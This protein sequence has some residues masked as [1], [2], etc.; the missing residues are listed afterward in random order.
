MQTYVKKKKD[1]S[2]ASIWKFLMWQ[3][4]LVLF[5]KTL[6]ISES[7]IYIKKFPECFYPQKEVIVNWFCFLSDGR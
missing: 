3:K 2:F 7:F 1:V 6:V 5:T 4:K